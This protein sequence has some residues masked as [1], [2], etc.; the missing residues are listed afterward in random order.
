MP[1][2]VILGLQW[3]DEGKGKVVD[4]FAPNYDIVARFQGG[5]NAGHTIIFDGK[6]YVLHLIPSGIFYPHT[7]C[8]I[9]NGV[10]IDPVTLRKE[11]LQLEASGRSLR[12]RILI[13][14]RAHLILPSHKLLDKASE[15]A[16]GDKKIGS[17]LRGIG[18]TYMDR[19]GRNGIRV[20]DLLTGSFTERYQQ[21]RDKH[22]KMLAHLY[23]FDYPLDELE[24]EFF[25]AIEFLQSL[26]LINTEA[27][28]HQALREGKQ[29][30]AE[31]AQGTLL[32]IE[33]GSYPY[34]TSSNTTTSGVCSGLGLPPTSI[35]KVFGVCKAYCTR[36]GSGPFPTE[37]HD[38]VGERLRELGGE[39]GATTGRP[40]RCGWLDLPLLKYAI[41]L[42]GVTDIVMT[43][44]DVLSELAEIPVCHSYQ[45]AQG[46]SDEIPFDL[47]SGEFEP[48][49]EQLSGWQTD[50]VQINGSAALPSQVHTYLKY[51]EKATDTPISWLS[52]GPDREQIM[53]MSPLGV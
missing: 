29:I 46:P 51:V 28:L 26:Q 23:R 19:T 11:I 25:E 53:E 13:S 34:V 2:D 21:L 22:V 18:P 12:D 42:N 49:Y 36:V 45:T 1:V 31:G 47:G 50:I 17:T 40:R 37:L 5:P 10:V 24:A 39:Y 6:K 15:V 52:V 20:G 48:V 41:R 16:K 27:L 4:V 44:A 14:Q 8:I 9:G 32:D 35:R 30:L 7:Q 43:K 33:F 3:G 38:E